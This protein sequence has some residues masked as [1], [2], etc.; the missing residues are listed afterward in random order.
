M[1]VGEYYSFLESEIG[2]K[3]LL[4][5]QRETELWQRWKQTKDEQA[6]TEILSS[7]LPFCRKIALQYAK[8][9]YIS[10]YDLFGEAQ[11][12]MIKA[13]PHYDPDNEAG[14]SFATYL[15][16]RLRGRMLEF[17]NRNSGPVLLYTTKPLKYLFSHWGRFNNQVLRGQRD[18]SDHARQTEIAK[19]AADKHHKITTDHVKAFEGR[20]YS[21]KLSL[22]VQADSNDSESA[23]FMDLLEDDRDMVTKLIEEEQMARHYQAALNSLRALPAREREIIKS[24]YLVEDN[25][26]QTLED[27][28]AKFNIT[29][30]RVRQLEVQ[31]LKALKTLLPPPSL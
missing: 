27:L 10:A 1:L 9:N 14:A 31:S 23:T 22:N 17:I 15:D 5:P 4:E 21:G 7:Y 28:G 29:K 6:R 3:S 30:E 26:K 18:I 13:F 16:K 12:E 20:L 2:V 8:K 11:L 25:Q 19:L 24:R